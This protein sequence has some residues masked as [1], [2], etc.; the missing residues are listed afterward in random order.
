MAGMKKKLMKKAK[1][2]GNGATQRSGQMNGNGAM[3]KKKKVAGK[4]GGMKR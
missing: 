4:K 1:K 3:T 2:N